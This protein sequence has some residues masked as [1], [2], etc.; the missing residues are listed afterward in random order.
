MVTRRRLGAAEQAFDVAGAVDDLRQLVARADALAHATEKQF[1]RVAPGD[2]P[3]DD[4]GR[5]REHLAHLLG[6]TAQAARAAA[7]ASDQIAVELAKHR[8]GAGT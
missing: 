4:D 6:A 5:Q 3:D 2:E 8:V 7:D 1:E